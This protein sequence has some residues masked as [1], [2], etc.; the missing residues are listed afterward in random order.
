MVLGRAVTE[1]AVITRRSALIGSAQPGAASRFKRAARLSIPE[2]DAAD[3]PDLQ[4][5]ISER[6]T[7]HRLEWE[8][9]LRP[10]RSHG[11]DPGRPPR[12]H[13]SRRRRDDRDH[14]RRPDDRHR[15]LP[16]QPEQQ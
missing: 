3:R 5:L 14:Q 2:H 4:H 15:I 13:V 12:G 8:P 11:L 6:R 9:S 16:I 7:Y 10:Q 1:T